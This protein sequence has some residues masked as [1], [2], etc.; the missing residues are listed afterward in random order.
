M[1]A[2]VGLH[3]VDVVA[4]HQAFADQPFGIQFQRR[5]VTP[6]LRIHHRLRKA[7]LVAFIVAEAAVA[8]HV[9]HHRPAEA[10]PELGRHA[11]DEHHRFRI[12]AVDVE[13][14]RLDHLGDVG[15]IRRGARI[16]RRGGEA[17][18]VVDDEMHRAAGAVALEAAEPEAFGDDAL[19]GERRVAV[20]QQRHHHR[21]VGR[22]RIEGRNARPPT[23]A[24]PAWRAPCPAPPDRRSSR[25]LGLAVR[26]RCTWL[27]S[28]SRSDEAPR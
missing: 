15:R 9:D 17:D 18:L 2:P 14:R 4:R 3:L 6:D 12:V 1:G 10:L 19:A 8:E 27:P 21:A 16:H 5:L 25:W 7:R 23:S 22:A 24:G 28:N 13:H 26:L 11:A 20:D